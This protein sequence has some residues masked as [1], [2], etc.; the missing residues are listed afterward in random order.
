MTRDE[1]P[2]VLRVLL[3]DDNPDDRALILRELRREFPHVHVEQVGR[4]EELADH[5]QRGTYDIAITDYH[6]NWSDGVAV[7]NA[8][9]AHH[10]GCP[11]IMFTATGTEEIAVQAM[12][13]GLDDYVIKNPQH[14]MRLS[15][16]IR[17]ALDRGK[18]RDSARA[19]TLRLRA[20]FENAPVGLYR[21]TPDGTILEGNPALVQIAGCSD[22]DALLKH[23]AADFFVS[24]RNFSEWSRRLEAERTIQAFEGP[25]RQLDGRRIWVRNSARVVTDER[26]NISFY[27]GALEDITEQHRAQ[28]EARLL[29]AVA[30]A[31]AKAED[32]SSAL[33]VVLREICLA[34]GWDLG[35]VWLPRADGAVLEC[36]P[37]WYGTEARLGAFHEASLHFAAKFGA[38]G[39]LGR[40]WV[41]RR[42]VWITDVTAD[43]N[44]AR[45][46]TAAQAGI[47]AAV[48]IP[49]LAVNE[50]VAV[51]EFFMREQRAEDPRLIEVVFAAASQLGPLVR[52]KRAEQSLRARE[53]HLRTVVD[54]EPECV[55]ILAA[56]GTLKEMNAAGLAMIEADD[57]EQAQGQALI[58]LIAPEHR[59]TFAAFMDSVAR[60]N[61]G[62]FEFEIV[63][64][65]GTRRWLESH[66]VPMVEEDGER[67]VLA[68]TRDITERKRAQAQL[69]F[70]A[71]HD[72]LTGLPNRALYTD[73]LQ[74][75]MIEAD[76]HK[77]MVGVVFLD[78]DR[79]KNVNDTLGHDAG[80]ALLKAVS[81]R[82]IGAVRKGDTVARLSGDEFTL[83]LA[84]MG[85]LEDAAR[86]A[87]KI[88]DVFVPPFHIGGRELYLTVSLGVTL[89]PVDGTDCQV[90]LRNADVAMYRAKDEGRNS[91][92]FYATEMTQR[93]ADQLAL[94]GALREAIAHDELR[95]HYQPIVKCG[96]S[97][98]IGV[99][100]LLRWQ[101][102]SRGLVSPL[103]FIPLAE[104][105]GMIV[106]I[107]EW[108]L[109]TACAQA[110]EWLRDHP[111]LRLAV[112]VSARQFRQDTLPATI[113]RVL[114]QTRF[115]AK[116][117][118][119]EITESVLLQQEKGVM[120][121]LRE[122]SVA[123]IAFSMDDFGT[124]YSSLSYL[125]RF[126]IAVLKIDRSFVRDIPGDPD[127]AA[128]AGAI[129][130]MAHALGLRVIAEGVETH[131]QSEFLSARGCD[132]LQ[133]YYFSRPVPADDIT[134]ML[135]TPRLGP[136]LKPAT[137]ARKT[138]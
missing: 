111:R 54:A 44:F 3:V 84:D 115:P 88:L 48:G 130:T 109:Q 106:Q 134:R 108:V 38:K 92:A 81:E 29:L 117:L 21:I 95:L 86:I 6:L 100:A 94:E 116:N 73:R 78:L 121:A 15:T 70:L 64:L 65:R 110:N 97:G 79:F 12:K 102:P 60:G 63:G 83:I 89:Y 18:Q 55:K 51:L 30:L 2:G 98:V 107:G 24:Q 26:G 128:I 119:L 67:V 43:A 16:A 19:T 113:G 122:L 25:G 132:A 85:Q 75:A 91:Y 28:E 125:K 124:G 42:P 32:L 104:E 46:D 27:E 61:K 77:R 87:Q 105:T 137:R 69:A 90:L 5:I 34:T 93:A 135:A 80:D 33:A 71:H 41:E 35:Q 13:A 112:N 127:D 40:T 138:P 68:V 1:A 4:A 50:V 58:K 136:A 129:I 36:A 7:L 31:M 52:R 47:R 82:L 74:Q 62:V 126:P 56:D 131:A 114:R 14:L 53:M 72:V 123:G 120:Q 39:L 99:E 66:A 101:H 96:D 118:E 49:V 11:V 17:L 22:L 57:L 8:I 37:V 103:E 45:A 133:G 10:P 23:N 9:K 59:A 76:R 20:I